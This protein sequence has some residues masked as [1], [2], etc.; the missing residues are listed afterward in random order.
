V[1]FTVKGDEPDVKLHETVE[2]LRARSAVFD[3]IT[4]PFPVTIDV[5]TA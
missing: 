2:R 5:S 1:Q 3:T 4:N